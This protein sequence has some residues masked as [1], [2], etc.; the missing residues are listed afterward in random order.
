MARCDLP[1]QR[2][3]GGSRLMESFRNIQFLE[4]VISQAL[5]GA[6]T[7]DFGSST[8]WAQPLDASQRTASLE[9]FKIQLS[10]LRLRSI[11]RVA[12]TRSTSGSHK[13]GF[14]L[15]WFAFRYREL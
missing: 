12:P 15:R 5:P 11:L 3:L 13:L 7:I 6:R 9:P 2:R 8:F 14:V 1:R 10:D 4:C